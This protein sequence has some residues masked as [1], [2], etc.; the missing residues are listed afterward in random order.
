MPPTAVTMAMV[1]ELLAQRDGPDGLCDPAQTA[2]ALNQWFWDDTDN[3]QFMTCVLADLDAE[4]GMLRFCQA[5]HPAPLIIRMTGQVDRLDSSDTPI[6]VGPDPF[7]RSRTAILSPGESVLLISD[8][9][10]KAV[11]CG[12]WQDPE[13]ALIDRLADCQADHESEVLQRLWR[14]VL[15][16][17]GCAAVADDVSALLVRMPGRPRLRT[18]TPR[19]T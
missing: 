9:I 13:A 15:R 18:V 19:R 11:D 16:S 2:E 14:N 12:H 4:T 17:G 3:D 10:L 1:S 5:G 7:Y 6:G 8:G